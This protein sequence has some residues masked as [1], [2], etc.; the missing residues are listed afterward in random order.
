M[1]HPRLRVPQRGAPRHAHPHPRPPQPA[2]PHGAVHPHRPAPP[3]ATNT[4]TPTATSIPT[5]TPTPTVTPTPTFVP[6]PTRPAVNVSVVPSS[7][8][9]LQATITVNGAVGLPSN[10]I[11]GLEIGTATNAVL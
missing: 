6:C 3:V 5:A 1:R 7:A 9:Q 2:H 10:Q 4:P 11:R 8:T